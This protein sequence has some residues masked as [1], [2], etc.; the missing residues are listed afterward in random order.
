[1]DSDPIAPEDLRFAILATDIALFTVRDGVLLTRLIAVNRPPH[2]PSGKGFPG[3]LIRPREDGRDAAERLL[4]SKAH[5][6]PN[7]VHLEQL[8][9]F[10]AIDR[11]PRGRV[12]ALAHLALVPWERLADSE[13]LDSDDAWRRSW[14]I[15]PERART[16]GT[17]R[18]PWSA[19]SW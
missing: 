18:R 4:A 2:F 14:P 7:H 1:M 12:V 8:Y 10:S 5:I 19:S 16:P 17:T 9:T 3:G 6:D 11:D 13:Q 15:R